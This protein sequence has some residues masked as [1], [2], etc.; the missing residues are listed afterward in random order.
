[1]RDNLEGC[2]IGQKLKENRQRQFAHIARRPDEH[3]TK[4]FDEQ[5]I[6]KK[7]KSENQRK[8]ANKQ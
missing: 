7:Q 3:I 2:D 5:Q 8:N 4:K 6:V 1:M